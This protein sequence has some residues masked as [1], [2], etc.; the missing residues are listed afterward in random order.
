MASCKYHARRCRDTA[1]NFTRL[2]CSTI[3]SPSGILDIAFSPHDPHLLCAA[4]STGTLDFYRLE[5]SDSDII[6]S[7]LHSIQ[8][9]DPSLLILDLEFHPLNASIIGTTLSSGAVQLITISSSSHTTFSTTDLTTHSLEA[10]T[11]SFSP[12]GTYLYTGGDDALLL[13]HPLSSNDQPIRAPRSHDAGVTSILPLRV[14][15]GVHT[16]ITGSYDDTLR[17]IS[18]QPGRRAVEHLSLPLGGGVWRL[19]VVYSTSEGEGQR[20]TLLA[21]CM[22]AGAAVVR[23]SCSDWVGEGRV[24]DAEVVK[25]FEEHRSMNYGGDVMPVPPG[26]EGGTRTVVSSSFYDRLV[27][28]WDNPGVKKYVHSRSPREW[29]EM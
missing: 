21:S 5:A 15:E 14:R 3:P 28:V 7:A 18:I 20:W 26:E 23:V 24:W 8:A 29:I 12:C 1:N 17:V 13:A 19:K 16:L 11:L 9:V 10:W 27:C 2:E 25:R 22:H 4:T 6:L